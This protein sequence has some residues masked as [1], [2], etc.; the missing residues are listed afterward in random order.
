MRRC[1]QDI[2]KTRLQT[3]GV[4]EPAPVLPPAAGGGGASQPHVPPRPSGAGRVFP[5]LRDIVAKEGWSALARG[6]GPRV[7]FHVPVCS[8][9]CCARCGRA[10]RPSGRGSDSPRAHLTQAAAICWGT[11]ETG[12]TALQKIER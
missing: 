2:A 8:P 6:I 4:W 11:Y 9:S 1:L 7:L 12:K 10:A 3:A 5:T